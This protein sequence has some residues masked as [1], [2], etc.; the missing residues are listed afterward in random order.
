MNDLYHFCCAGQNTALPD[1]P[2]DGAALA[3]RAGAGDSAAEARSICS[4]I[5]TG[6]VGN[7][8]LLVQPRG[9]LYVAGGIASHLLARMLSPR[10]MAAATD[11]GR[12]RSVSNARRFS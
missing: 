8:A 9:G 10:F 4:S 12:L 11:K 1:E 3:A 2:V 7:V 5:Y 6:L